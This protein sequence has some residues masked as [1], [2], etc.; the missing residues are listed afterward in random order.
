MLRPTANDWDF[1]LQALAGN[2]F[3]IFSG[4]DLVNPVMALINGGNVG[5]GTTNPQSKLDV[6]GTV[7]ATK[8][9]V[10]GGSHFKMNLNHC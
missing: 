1:R 10:S 6:T 5:I 7:K 4:G 8:L 9:N 3:G 2:K